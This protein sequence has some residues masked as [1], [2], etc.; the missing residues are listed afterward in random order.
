M[1]AHVRGRHGTALN[2]KNRFHARAPRGARTVV[3]AFLCLI[4]GRNGT[5][6]SLLMENFDNAPPGGAYVAGLTGTAFST[7][8]GNT[9][10]I[11]TLLN[12]ASAGYKTCPASGTGINNC[13]D[14]NGLIPGAVRSNQSFSLTAGTTYTLA[15]SA[16]GSIPAVVGIP[17][18]FTVSLGAS[19]PTLFTVP[20]GGSFAAGR[21]IYTP[22]INETA[23]AL[24]LASATDLGGS[25][26]EYGPLIDNLVLSDNT[27][28]PPAFV[29]LRETFDA[30]PPGSNFSTSLG[31]SRFTVRSGNVDVLGHLLNGADTGFFT[32]PDALTD[33]GN[34]VDLNGDQ[35]GALES[36]TPFRLT[37]GTTYKVSFQL[38]GGEGSGTDCSHPLA[39]SL[40]ASGAIGFCAPTGGGFMPESF[41]YTP[42]AHEN[43]ASLRFVSQA[44]T[45][46]PLYGPYIDDISV[47]EVPTPGAALWFLTALAA[48]GGIRRWR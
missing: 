4:G 8:V 24:V 23:A 15:F 16:A 42:A 37:S 30:T 47:T 13:L 5:A 7:V 38:A 21:F 34:C 31:G 45:G 2:K 48:L 41:F 43:E 29:P 27:A 14:L 26:R 18:A 6:A 28:P 19:G 11:G 3:V 9:D 12:G 40:G 35:P 46:N 1:K 33:A 44:T 17:Y 32:C 22:A 10:V 36:T 20:D 39:V 25:L